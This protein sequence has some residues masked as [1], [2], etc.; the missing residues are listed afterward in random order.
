MNAFTVERNHFPKA[1]RQV[2]PL[3]KLKSQHAI[4]SRDSV[5]YLVDMR[6]QLG[7]IVRMADNELTAHELLAS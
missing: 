7:T 4:V 1:L 6:R 5:D 3:M 2:V